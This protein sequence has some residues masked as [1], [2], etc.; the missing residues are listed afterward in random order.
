M[1]LVY[2]A[3]GNDS[4]ENERD[5]WVR[6][7]EG[8]KEKWLMVRLEWRTSRLVEEGTSGNSASS[9][10]TIIIIHWST[11]R[12]YILRLREIR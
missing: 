11:S 4:E 6:M 2:V 8:A 5:V 3:A 1:H 12:L 7:L 10:A 9:D